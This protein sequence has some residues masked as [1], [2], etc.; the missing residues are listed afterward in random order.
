M[1][2]RRS[3]MRWLGFALPAIAVTQE[4][5][6]AAPV[7][8]E[9]SFEPGPL[10]P[11]PDDSRVVDLRL[12]LAACSL[13]ARGFVDE[14]DYP[15]ARHHWN[16]YDGSIRVT[17]DLGQIPTDPA[18]G[19]PEYEDVLALRRKFDAVLRFASKNLPFGQA[20]TLCGRCGTPVSVDHDRCSGCGR[21]IVQH[22][23]VGISYYAEKT[24]NSSRSIGYRIDES[25]RARAKSESMAILDIALES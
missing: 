3:I 18:C 23:L 13:A 14:I 10:M 5:A 11:A 4:V 24:A 7:V 21:N 9:M 2:N 16:Y 20:V 25:G 1:V 22:E 12:K 6:K 19:S 8:P 15:A 17:P